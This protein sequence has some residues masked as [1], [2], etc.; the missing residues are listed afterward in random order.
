MFRVIK[1]LNHNGVL[2]INMDN[3][4]EY[5]LLGKGI[6]FGKKS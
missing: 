1:A 4:K 6:G 3:Y 2:A 5:I